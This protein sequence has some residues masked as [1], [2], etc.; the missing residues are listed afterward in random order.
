ML[1]NKTIEYLERDPDH[2]MLFVLLVSSAIALHSTLPLTLRLFTTLRHRT[3]LYSHAVLITSWGLSLRQLGI[4]TSFLPRRNLWI[5]RLI[6]VHIGWPMMVTGFSLVLYSRLNIICQNQRIRRGVLVMIVSNAV[7]WH[8]ALTI[9]SAEKARGRNAGN[10]GRLPVWK[11]LDFYLER[12]QIVAFNS[13]ESI[14]SAFYMVHSYRYMK[15]GFATKDKKRRDMV[16]LVLVQIVIIAFDV[17][18]VAIDFKGLLQLKLFIHSAVY[19]V[20]LELEFVILNQLVEM[21]QLGSAVSGTMV[22]V[23][24]VWSEARVFSEGGKSSFAERKVKTCSSGSF[25]LE[26]QVSRESRTSRCS[27]DFIT[28]PD[29]LDIR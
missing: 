23:A 24:E 18:M 10:V 9:T 1:T 13:Q 27:L 11:M 7:V 15:S 16:V 14:I 25:D 3:G 17:A 21:S 29:H 19:S 26:S 5:P 22:P 28:T 8:T 6:L 2:A 12:F 4:L 20:K